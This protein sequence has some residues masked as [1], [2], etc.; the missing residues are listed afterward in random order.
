M[1]V[2]LAA[3]IDFDY[4]Q[5]NKLVGDELKVGIKNSDNQKLLKSLERAFSL[6]KDNPQAGAQVKK[7]QIPKKYVKNYGVTNLWVF[8]LVNYWRM[9]YTI[10]SEGVRVLNVILDIVDHKT[11]DKIFG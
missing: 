6:L 10:T 2:V 8:D 9:I 7:Q 1:G 4:N 11:Y 5:L 3:E